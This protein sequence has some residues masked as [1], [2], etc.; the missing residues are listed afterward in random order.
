[1]KNKNEYNGDWKKNILYIYKIKKYVY[2]F[3][4]YEYKVEIFVNINVRDYVKIRINWGV[5]RIWV[6]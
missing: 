3:N 6:Y 1:M 5:V 4:N 2:L